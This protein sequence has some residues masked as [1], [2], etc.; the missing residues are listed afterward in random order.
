[1]RVIRRCLLTGVTTYSDVGVQR[2]D[3]RSGEWNDLGERAARVVGTSSSCLW[4]FFDLRSFFFCWIEWLKSKD[5]QIIRS[6]FLADPRAGLVEQS[7]SSHL[8][9]HLDR[10]LPHAP[11]VAQRDRWAELGI[12]ALPSIC[13]RCPREECCA[14]LCRR[15]HAG[16]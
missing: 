8:W 6:S 10:K 2:T 14:M 1:M 9:C 13:W 16:V 11:N 4:D 12:S 7:L 5:Q 3:A 15:H